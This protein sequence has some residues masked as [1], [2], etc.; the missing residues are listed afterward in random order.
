MTELLGGSI[1]REG[2]MAVIR[3]PLSQVHSFRIALQPCPCKGSKS[4][5]TADIRQ[6]IEK[7]LARLQAGPVRA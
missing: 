3:I 7:G 2:D 6:S 5:A 1:K 4:Q